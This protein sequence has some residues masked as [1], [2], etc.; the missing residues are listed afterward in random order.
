MPICSYM[1]DL[2]IIKQNKS[3]REGQVL[4]DMTYMQKV[5]YYTN[6]TETNPQTKR[7]DLWLPRERGWGREGLGVWDQQEQTITITYRMDKQGPI[8]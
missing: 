5:K 3:Q 2:E 1:D 7:T 8:I 4:Y 6:E